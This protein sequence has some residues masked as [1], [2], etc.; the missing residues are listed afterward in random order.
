M[1]KII[2]NYIKYK[3]LFKDDIKHSSYL[4][5]KVFR[6]IYGYTQNVTK[7]DKK[8]YLY[9]RE[10]TLEN[11]PYIRPG[12]NSIIV[13]IN[14]E[15][16][17][18]NFFNTGKSTTH[19]FK[20]KGEWSIDYTIDKIE[21]NDTD[22]IKAVENFIDNLNIVSIDGNKQKL[23]EELNKLI[24]NSEYLSKYKKA[25]KDNLLNKLKKIQEI[26]WIN[27]VKEKSEKVN[28]FYN[29]INKIKELFN[30]LKISQ[31]QAIKDD[32]KESLSIST[33]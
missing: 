19:N 28:S 25:N 4:Y 15:H 26:D 33:Q 6:S 32:P 30:S 9:H 31:I 5:Q 11:T 17:I 3:F 29:N 12:K 1:D 20:E 10:G 18:I 24:A 22:I 13:P 14:T 16:N 8:T 21:I 23:S 2:S 7:K 27:K